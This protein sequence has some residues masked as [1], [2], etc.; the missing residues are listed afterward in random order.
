MCI[1]QR[2]KV[3]CCG[4]INAC[5]NLCSN[6]LGSFTAHAAGL[7]GIVVGGSSHHDVH[8]VCTNDM[9]ALAVGCHGCAVVCQ[10][11]EGGVVCHHV[12]FSIEGSLSISVSHRAGVDEFVG[13][14]GDVKGQFVISFC[15]I[16]C[17]KH[18]VGGRNEVV[19]LVGC[20]FVAALVVHT[21]HAVDDVEVAVVSLHGFAV[22]F[23]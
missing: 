23:E 9:N 14:I 15:F 8:P 21:A 22:V 12:E 16:V 2:F 18:L 13:S 10:D 6:L 20:C 7:G 11:F 4:S 17:H 19:A 1:Q 5:L 3:F